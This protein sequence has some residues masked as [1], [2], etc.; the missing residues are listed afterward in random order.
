MN[1]TRPCQGE[2]QRGSAARGREVRSK[3]EREVLTVKAARFVCTD[4]VGVLPRG[5][6]L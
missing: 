6:E 5:D 3:F 4:Q 2:A 1:N